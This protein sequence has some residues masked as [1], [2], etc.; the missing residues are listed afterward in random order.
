[1]LGAWRVST[2]QVLGWLLWATSNN[3]GPLQGM[4][5]DHFGYL[6]FR[7]VRRVSM[8]TSTVRV[9]T[10][11]LIESPKYEYS[12]YLDTKVEGLTYKAH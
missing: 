7:G 1:M 10:S 4:V 8:V 2:W 5:T 6:A 12:L 3:S 11:L 9:L